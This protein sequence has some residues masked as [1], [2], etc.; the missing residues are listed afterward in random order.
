MHSQEQK[1]VEIQAPTPKN[2]WSTPAWLY[3][4]SLI[5][6][7]PLPMIQPMRSFGMAI[8]VVVCCC[9]G[10]AGRACGTVLVALGYAAAICGRPG[11]VATKRNHLFFII[12]THG[13]SIHFI[14]SFNIYHHF[15]ENFV[16]LKWQK[17]IL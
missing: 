12:V 4:I 17:V 15:W 2:S 1:M 13:S 3:L 9:W 11:I 5:F 16:K 10:W 7:P 6:C 14:Y 8:S